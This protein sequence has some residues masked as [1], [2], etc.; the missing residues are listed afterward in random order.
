VALL[1]FIEA[2]FTADEFW[3]LVRELPNAETLE[4]SRPD[5]VSWHVAAGEALALLRRCGFVDAA[6]IL[7]LVR[8]RP[9]FVRDVHVAAIAAGVEVPVALYLEALVEAGHPQRGVEL[10]QVL[11]GPPATASNHAL[12]QMALLNTLPRDCAPDAWRAATSALGT[13]HVDADRDPGAPVVGASEIHGDLRR[14]LGEAGDLERAARLLL[15]LAQRCRSPRAVVEACGELKRRLP[16]D[17]RGADWPVADRL[18]WLRD[19][20]RRSARILA[21]DRPPSPTTGDAVIVRAADLVKRFDTGFTL[22][23]GDREFRSGEIVGILGPNGA[24]KSSLLRILAG[25]LA[26][27]AG[28]LAYP[29][30]GVDRPVGDGDWAALKPW[31]RYVSKQRRGWHETLEDHLSAWASLRGLRGEANA[32]EIEY[33]IERLGLAPHRSKRCDQLSAGFRTR[34]EIA[35]AFL[36]EPRLLVLDE[37][38]A[39]L[40][41]KAQHLVLQDLRDLLRTLPTPPALVLS[42]Q[43]IHEIEPYVH[44]VLVLRG[45]GAVEYDGAP[46]AISSMF[47]T[48]AFELT[49][50]LSLSARDLLRAREPACRFFESDGVSILEVPK[51]CR[52]QDLT[53]LLTWGDDVVYLRE[54]SGSSMRLLRRD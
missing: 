21:D 47:A 33:L 39:L 38:L 51:S 10:L 43:H 28:I 50:P 52:V 34:L 5:A 54:I 14:A 45:D 13:A 53:R 8:A 9:R 15:D 35:R 24:G 18:A 30:L 37:P 49:Q 32:S 29:A 23:V 41:I 16:R 2:R 44:R 12:L 48:R 22:Q 40:D 31:I 42:S 4:S 25:D 1:A 36:G 3:R 7:A 20:L 26:H 46:S 17:P 19:L 27:D 6:L 11:E